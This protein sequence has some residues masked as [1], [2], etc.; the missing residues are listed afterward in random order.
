MKRIPQAIPQTLAFFKLFE[1]VYF[2]LSHPQM[3]DAANTLFVNILFSYKYV[4][5]AFYLQ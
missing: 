3:I 5:S 1:L 4:F 2:S